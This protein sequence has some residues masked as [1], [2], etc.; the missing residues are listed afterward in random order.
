MEL[1]V[2]KAVVLAAM[3]GLSLAF[4]LL[5]LKFV[6]LMRRTADYRRRRQYKRY[7]SFLSCFGGG[8]FLSACLLDLYPDVQQSLR[9]ALDEFN[10]VTSFPLIDFVVAMGFFVMFI[11]EQI[12]LT[13]KEQQ[14]AKARGKEREP[15]LC[16]TDSL[17]SSLPNSR[18]PA[19]DIIDIERSYDDNVGEQSHDHSMLVSVHED[20]NSRSNLRTLVLLLAISLH[21]IF[22]G[23]AI[24][25]ETEIYRLWE[26][27]LAV[28]IH[29][30]I[31]ALSLG[32]NLIQTKFKL[33]FMVLC[34][35][36]FSAAAPLGI[37]IGMS[38]INVGQSKQT[39]LAAG[40]L[41]GLACG[42]FLYVTF[43]EIL[44]HEMNSSKDRLLKVLYIILGFSTICA[45]LFLN[46]AFEGN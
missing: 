9:K 39:H 23:L 11:T 34:S 32:M 27:L 17:S 38:V 13:Y 45:A 37:G 8:V 3:F 28:G 16:S 46:A 40:L 41:Q 15:L 1:L 24:G 6:S 43:F 30:S 18:E 4:S 5:P 21:S 7:L 26:L 10:I 35:V 44:P 2:I 33:A 19:N 12:V 29:K 31:I 25:L 14:I 22:E 42:T 20:P 36:I